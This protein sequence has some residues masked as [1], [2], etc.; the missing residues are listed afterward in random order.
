MVPR[1]VDADQQETDEKA[2]NLWGQVPNSAQKVGFICNAIVHRR[3]LDL[4]DEERNRDSEHRVAEKYDAFQL[5][6]P[7]LVVVSRAHMTFLFLLVVLSPAA[8]TLTLG[9]QN[10]TIVS[11]TQLRPLASPF[12]HSSLCREPMPFY[13]IPYDGTPDTGSVDLKQGRSCR[14]DFRPDGDWD[15]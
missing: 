5:K 9:D 12:L 7:A 8:W 4:N 11:N 15:L 13:G 6:C 3:Y 2:E 10:S 1:P 14:R